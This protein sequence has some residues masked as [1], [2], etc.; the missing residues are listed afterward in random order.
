MNPVAIQSDESARVWAALGTVSDPEIPVISVV[1]LGIIADAVVNAG[2]VRVSMLPTFVGCPALELMRS[3]IADAVRGAGFA[4]VQ[5]DVVLDP[6]W[7]TDRI[8]PAGLE[9][10]QEFGLAL[11][12]ASCGAGSGETSAVGTGT[13]AAIDSNF[14]QVPCPLCG[15]RQTELE[16]IFGPTL[17]RAIHY[18]H[19][20]RQSFEQFKPVG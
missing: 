16:S 3:Q 7:T 10:L 11:P 2:R 8:T 18:C 20:C 12:G 17:C 6:P 19:A 1:D 13:H 9:R 15:S 5:V 4:D 14:F